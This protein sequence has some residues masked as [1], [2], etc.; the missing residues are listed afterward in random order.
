MSFVSADADEKKG[1]EV[2]GIWKL[3]KYI[4]NG[5]PNEDVVKGN[6][7]IVRKDGLQE[8]TKDGKP[9]SKAKF[10]VDPAKTPK[11]IDFIDD[12]GIRVGGVYEI[13]GDEM[14]VAILADSEKRKRSRPSALREEGNIIAVYEHVKDK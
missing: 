4:E 11:H 1:T 13:K 6:Y 2:D 3:T 8:I 7:R 14:R 12:K 10:E 5:K 9:F